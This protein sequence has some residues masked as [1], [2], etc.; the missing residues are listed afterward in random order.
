MIEMRRLLDVARPQALRWEQAFAVCGSL[1]AV[2]LFHHLSLA[3]AI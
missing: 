1:D 2:Q 3:H